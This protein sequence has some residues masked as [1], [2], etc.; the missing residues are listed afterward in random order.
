M[1]NKERQIIEDDVRVLRQE[2]E[3]GQDRYYL[4]IRGDDRHWHRIAERRTS[5]GIC[6][7]INR[8]CSESN[9]LSQHIVRK[10]I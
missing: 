6:E 8:I 2:N 4:E 3:Q 9:R 7:E 1:A 10:G 5:R